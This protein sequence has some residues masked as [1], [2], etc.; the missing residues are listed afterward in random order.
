MGQRR[1]DTEANT[2]SYIQELIETDEYKVGLK[3]K[4]LERNEIERQGIPSR[5]WN[6]V[7]QLSEGEV[8]QRVEVRNVA[9]LGANR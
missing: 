6:H 3:Q 7:A 1:L 9:I 5:V 8:D 2:L 4:N